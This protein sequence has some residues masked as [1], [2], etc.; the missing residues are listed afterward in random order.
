MS[1]D[2]E[3]QVYRQFESTPLRADQTNLYVD[4]DD[5][6]GNTSIVHRLASRIRLAHQTTSQVLAGHRGSGKS[7]ELY[8]LQKALE[9]TDPKYFVIFCR[10]DEDLDR[11]D[12]DFP[13]ILIAIVRQ[14]AKQ[15]REK[16]DF[17]LKPGLF[18]DRFDRLVKSLNKNDLN[19]QDDKL[20][21]GLHKIGM[22]IKN[23]PDA[24]TEIR[25]L[26]E[27]DA[28]N[29]LAA[30]NDV[31]GQAV[32]ALRKKGY[33]GL[34]II[35]DD[36]DKMIVRPH[37]D[38]GRNT[39]EYLFIHRSSQLM[40]FECHTVFTLPLSLTYSH[41]E[42]T[43]K[44][45]YGGQVPVVPMIK[46]ATA[47]PN[48]RSYPKGILKMEELVTTRLDAAGVSLD[49][50]FEKQNLLKEMIKL[51]GGQPTELMTLLREA[52]IS[53]GLPVKSESL[54]RAVR[55][56]KREY[57][58]QLRLEHWPILEQVRTTGKVE[59]ARDDSLFRELLDSRAL[60]QYVNDVEWYGL[61]PMV[62]ALDSPSSPPLPP[63]S[64]DE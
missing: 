60:I 4:L 54:R 52:I 42:S 23:S 7:T 53:H 15:I 8:L 63:P 14:L 34:V 6:R 31:I 26:L 37:A 59:R 36:L 2:L 17:E 5:V 29:W 49:Q 47:P 16:A 48:P 57:A 13:D 1:Q 12:I 18:Q 51:S 3:T 45:L 46:I 39:A 27:P 10:A 11:N 43:I 25:K 50:V 19:L 35:V 40:A 22:A 32:V 44:N 20:D 30:A 33:E 24:R 62:A 9:T 21:L 56:G 61:N 28:G 58:R 64:N 38:T 41:H 55:E